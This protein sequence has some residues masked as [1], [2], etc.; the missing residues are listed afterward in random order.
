MK[1][2]CSWCLKKITPTL[3]SDSKLQR[4]L[5]TCQSCGK[6]IVK[7]RACENYARYDIHEQKDVK[8]KHH[9]KRHFDQF[10]LEHRHELRDFSKMNS[11]LKNP[12]DYRIVYEY[13]SANLSKAG[14]IALISSLGAAVTGP[15]FYIA[16][17][18]IGGAIGAKVAGLSGA[19]ATNYGLALLGFG[20]LAA[21]GFGMAGG[22]VVVTA[23]GTA[24][25]GAVG[26]YIGNNYL[27]DIYKFDIVQIK[28]GKKPAIITINGFLSEKDYKNQKGFQDWKK[29]IKTHYPD[30]E[31]Y[32]IYWEA[33]SLYEIGSLITSTGASVLTSAAIAKAAKQA[34]KMATK[35]IGPLGTVL[36]ALQLSKNPWHV[37]LRKAEETGVLLADILKRTNKKYI[38]LA[39][40]LGCRVAY[41]TMIGLSTT[42]EK[43]IEEVH[44]TGGAVDRKKDNWKMAKKSVSG[45]IFNYYSRNDYVLRFLYKAGTFF[46]NSPIGLSK[47]DY[48]KGIRNYDVTR[49]VKG[50][51]EYKS[52][53]HRFLKKC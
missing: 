31:W 38:I 47:I 51:M 5:Y 40:S 1:G 25:G 37:A 11:K 39:H 22:M 36:T 44:L 20:S 9:K 33:K 30:N 48:I 17:P 46:T 18:A 28:N 23:A 24:L 15:F 43:I 8:G 13:N 6:K 35:K 45:K 4:N 21:G 53:A 27:R 3:I 50:H 29:V 12:S 52:N 7:C 41:S 2:Y 49:H 10:C 19:V 14:R 42:G 16:G 32:H 26:A 34:T